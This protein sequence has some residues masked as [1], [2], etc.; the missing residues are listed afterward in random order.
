MWWRDQYYTAIAD[1]VRRLGGYI[2]D[3]FP[4]SQ[5]DRLEII[6]E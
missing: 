4:D 3:C 1:E 6:V 5:T 2:I